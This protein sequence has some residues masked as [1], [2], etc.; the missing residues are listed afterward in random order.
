MN[1][2]FRF[3]GMLFRV[4]SLWIVIGFLAGCGTPKRR[5]DNSSQ[6]DPAPPPSIGSTDLLRTGDALI[7]TFSGVI[8]PPPQVQDRINEDGYISLPY[9]GRVKAAGM[10]RSKLQ[11]EIYNLYFPKYFNARLTVTVNPDIRFFYVGGEVR[12]PGNY[13]YVGGMTALKA[14]AAAGDFTDYAKK[15]EVQITR[16]SGK[17]ETLDCNKAQ[18]EPGQDLIIFPDDRIFVPRRLF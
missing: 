4:L 7:V 12:K 13:A 9:V 17:V 18:K 5:T 14:I 6:N 10:T 1:S 15:W 3:S 16:S 2:A 8:E 11:D